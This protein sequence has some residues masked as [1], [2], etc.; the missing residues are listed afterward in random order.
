MTKCLDGTWCCGSTSE[1]CCSKNEGF[2]LA[3]TISPYIIQRTQENWLGIGLGVA[4]GVV[5]LGSAAVGILSFRLYR[6]RRRSTDSPEGGIS[7]ET[8]PRT[9]AIEDSQRSGRSDGTW[10]SNRTS[11]IELSPHSMIYEVQE[12]TELVE[13]DGDYKRV[14][15]AFEAKAKETF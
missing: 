9:R 8:R 11:H 15:S 4:L 5:L 3:A 12:G 1:D 6:T 13:L 2:K 7:D 10:I 14:S